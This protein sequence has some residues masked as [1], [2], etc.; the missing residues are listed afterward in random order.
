MTTPPRS[1]EDAVKKLAADVGYAACGITTTAPFHD[2]EKAIGERMRRFPEAAGLYRPMLGRADPC[3]SAPWAKS[4]VVC[5]RWYGKYELPPE[6]I[7][8]FG[9]AYL[10]DRRFAE[11][12][13]HDMPRRMKAGLSAMGFR[14]KTGGAPCRPAAIRAGIAL[15]TGNCFAWTSAHGSWINIECWLVDADLSPDCPAGDRCPCPEGCRACIDACPTGALADRFVMRMDRCVAYLTYGAPEPVVPG[16]EGKMGGWMYGCDVCQEVCPLNAGK[17]RNVEKAGWM[18]RVADSLK[19]ENIA[20]MTA[21][22]C[23]GVLAPRFP[24]IPADNL[25]RWRANAVRALENTRP[26]AK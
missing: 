14:V 10:A 26:R 19:P 18:F 2:Y 15:Q 25:T 9:R 17:W 5:L 4:I 23:A 1:R 3:A 22:T 24:Y 20:A 16:L 21:D 13:D 12:P 7:G 11:C 6:T 8:H